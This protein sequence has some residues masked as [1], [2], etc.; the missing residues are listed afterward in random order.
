MATFASLEFASRRSLSADRPRRVPVGAESVPPRRDQPGL[1]LP[2]GSQTRPGHPR[3][4]L[5]G[6]GP[7]EDDDRRE[8]VAASGIRL[9]RD[10]RL[11]VGECVGEEGVNEVE[12]AAAAPEVLHEGESARG[13]ELV[14]I[15]GEEVGAGASEAVD[16][17]LDV[18]DEEEPASSE[19]VSGDPAD[20]LVLDRVGV[21]ELVDEDQ[22]VAIR[23]LVADGLG[24]VAEE[25]AGDAGGGR[26]SRAAP[27]RR[28]TAANSRR[29]QAATPSPGGRPEDRREVRVLAS[30]PT[31]A[32]PAIAG[33]YSSLRSAGFRRCCPAGL[34]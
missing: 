16:R 10:D 14:A 34:A 32:R 5:E 4:A 31:P 27:R 9:A 30:N 26:R 13:G 28:L 17:L 1:P 25:V 23:Q 29:A 20:D 19:V 6:T 18:A 22:V 21:L 3:V 24:V 33:S 12:E 7:G 2:D 11:V 15:S 8:R